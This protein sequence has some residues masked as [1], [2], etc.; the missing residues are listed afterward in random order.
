MTGQLN[1]PV[2]EVFTNSPQH[3]NANIAIC[4]LDVPLLDWKITGPWKYPTLK[5][6]PIVP[7]NIKF[8]IC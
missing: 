2:F 4:V 6:N 1:G 5:C 7:S 3:K 8:C